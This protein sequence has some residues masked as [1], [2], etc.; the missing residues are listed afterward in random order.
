MTEAVRYSGSIT[1]RDEPAIHAAVDRAAK[2]RR[3]KPSEWLRQ[4][5]RTALQLDGIEPEP[6]AP[7]DAGALYDVVEGQR[8]WAWI[9]ADAIK[10]VHRFPADP[11]TNPDQGGHTWLPVVYVDAEPFDASTHWRL[12]P[13]YSIEADKVV[14]TFPVVAKSGEV[15]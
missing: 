5:I 14:C 7:R 10:A 1:W 9:E 8:A 12:P 15:A 2:A 3:T 13:V 11:A 4:A 6:I